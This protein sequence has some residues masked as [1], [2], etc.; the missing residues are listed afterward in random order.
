MERKVVGME[1]LGWV[2]DVSVDF[3]SILRLTPFY[4]SFPAAGLW[5]PGGAE[6]GGG[7]G[8]AGACAV[9]MMHIDGRVYMV[10]TP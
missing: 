9:V 10:N 5:P 6:Q 1:G 8:Q 7:Q 2:A 3:R 4:V